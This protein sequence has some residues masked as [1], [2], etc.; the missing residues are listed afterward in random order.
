MAPFT[1]KSAAPPTVT[2][3]EILL[4]I[5]DTSI[6]PGTIQAYRETHYRIEGA[7]PITL[8]VG[9]PC[10]ALAR[11]HS[12]YNVTCSAF[13]TPCNPFSGLLSDDENRARHMAL[14]HDLDEGHYAYLDGVGQ[15]PSNDWPGEKIFLILGMTL[16]EAKALGTRLEQ[17]AILWNGADAIP[18]LIFLA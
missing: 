12:T 3:A 5:S 15:H 6:D 10:P 7:E 2:E 1:V 16:A 9:V 4:D 18:Q 17:N 14:A 11:L 8:K 13:I